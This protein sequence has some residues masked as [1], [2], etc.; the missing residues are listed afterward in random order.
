MKLKAVGLSIAAIAVVTNG[1]CGGAK[2]SGLFT[3]GA[4]A[5]TVTVHDANAPDQGSTGGDDQTADDASPN[6]GPDADVA[7]T[8]A[9]PDDASTG[10]PITPCPA[11]DPSVGVVEV[12]VDKTSYALGNSTWSQSGQNGANSM[13]ATWGSQCDG[14]VDLTTY[15]QAG[16]VD[17]DT[18]MRD[19]GIVDGP[20]ITFRTQGAEYVAGFD[21][22]NACN[23]CGS[24]TITVGAWANGNVSGSFD[25]QAKRVGSG[26]TRAFTGTFSFHK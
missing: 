8:S 25:V 3:G 4:D 14:Q 20:R 15:N 5:G 23:P 16:A 13:T 2:D 24:G 26:Q 6:P 9:P 7:D 12:T 22:Q 17:V 11:A 10:I 18:R 21:L 1:A 19:A